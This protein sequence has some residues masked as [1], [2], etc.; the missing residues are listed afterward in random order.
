MTTQEKHKIVA[1]L[2]DPWSPLD[3]V[4]L[5]GH[6]LISDHASTQEATTEICHAA[7][8]VALYVI[9]TCLLS[10]W[11]LHMLAPLSRP[12]NLHGFV[13][14]TVD[15]K[16]SS[17][18]FPFH[19]IIVQYA[20]SNAGLPS[21]LCTKTVCCLRSYFMSWQFPWRFFKLGLLKLTIAHHVISVC[22]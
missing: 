5:C 13:S 22:Q 2:N 1:L 4:V 21:G 7:T 3:T 20:S 17:L 14:S 8:D 15:V 9:K 6:Y 11:W 18:S 10:Q 19:L 12:F 16:P